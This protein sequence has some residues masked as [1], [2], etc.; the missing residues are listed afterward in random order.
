MRITHDNTLQTKMRLF[1]I[2]ICLPALSVAN[3]FFSGHDEGWFWYQEALELPKENKENPNPITPLTTL[4]PTEHMK[5]YQRKVEDSLNLAILK[6]NETNLKA[7]AKNY[8]EVIHRG[9]RFTD[10]YQRMLLKN[11]N[12]DYTLQFPVNPLA[13]QVY[14]E[15]KEIH[16]ETAIRDFAKSHG[17]FFFL[18]STCQY[19]RVFAPI[20]KS[21]AKK[22]NISVLAISM[23]SQKLKEFPNAIEN[24]DAFRL[25]KVTHLPALFAVNPK[26][27]A[28]IPIAH[29]A[30]SLVQLEENILRVVE[31]NKLK[32]QR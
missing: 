17:L 14:A 24:R 6:P 13:Q 1:V 10:A 2:L 15:Q 18:S 23:D 32:E 19:C 25:F 8:F 11:P 31:Y 5:A 9:Q 12:F 20:V 3:T 22:Y 4:S 26:T 16:L 21:F 30:I 27:K 28:V 29:G 7:Y